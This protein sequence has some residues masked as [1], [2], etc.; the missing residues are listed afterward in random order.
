[1]R[2]LGARRRVQL[3]MMLEILL[4]HVGIGCWGRHLSVSGTPVERLLRRIGVKDRILLVIGH[5]R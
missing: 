4:E 3:L 5:H 2:N 1:M